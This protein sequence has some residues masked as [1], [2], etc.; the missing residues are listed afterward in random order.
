MRDLQA[1][2]TSGARITEIDP[3]HWRLSIPAGTEECYRVAQL[4]DFSKLKRSHF[5]W[6]SPVTLKVSARVSSQ[7]HAGTWG[8]GFWND[9]FTLSLGISGASRRLPALPN[10]AWFFY[11][12]P[13]NYLSFCNDQ[14]ANGM[15]AGVFSSPEIPSPLL[16]PGAVLL[17]LMLSRFTTPLLRWL[18]SLFVSETASKI[19][20]NWKDW[21]QFAVCLEKDS[22]TFHID[23]KQVFQSA[24][25]P[26]SNLGLVI[27]IDN[28]FA[29]LAPG[30]RF[31]AGKLK[32]EKESWLEIQDLNVD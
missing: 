17:P 1:Q 13:H 10:A 2:N 4:D 6:Q 19:H 11:A 32:T 24:I 18:I 12:S 31:R 23:G 8:F 14:P 30:E 28:Q 26:H 3:G 22:A 5:H 29:R 21:H 25:S 20:R 15:L 16:A 9:P 7:D 27:W